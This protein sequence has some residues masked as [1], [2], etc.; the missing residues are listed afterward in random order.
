MPTPGTAKGRS[1]YDLVP[2][3]VLLLVSSVCTFIIMLGPHRGPGEYVVVAPYW[4][5]FTQTF[6]LIV[7]ADGR[8]V[9]IGGF[10]NVVI[11][12]SND[13]GFVYT[14]Y[15][16]GALLVLDPLLLRGCL[17]FKRSI[18]VGEGV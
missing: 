11:V 4:Y 6:G 13:P 10:A 16:T 17:G 5:T 7:E 2:A 15:R 14:V 3:T 1:W 12:R 18:S 9:D 8:I